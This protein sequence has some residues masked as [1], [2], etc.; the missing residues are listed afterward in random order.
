[1]PGY[2]AS[3]TI[4]VQIQLGGVFPWKK[5]PS[6]TVFYFPSNYGGYQFFDSPT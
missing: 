4:P 1:M 2:A 6:A 3:G 5:K